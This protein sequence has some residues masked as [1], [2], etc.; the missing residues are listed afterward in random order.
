MLPDPN[1]SAEARLARSAGLAILRR[2]LR[3]RKFEAIAPG[4]QRFAQRFLELV[5]AL[6]VIGG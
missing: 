4:L 2:R 1:H 3:I 5:D 6:A